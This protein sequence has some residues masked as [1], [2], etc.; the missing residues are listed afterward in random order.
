LTGPLAA[1]LALP[2]LRRHTPV[3]SEVLVTRSKRW[4]VVVAGIFTVSA[5]MLVLP[6]DASAQRR[7]VRRPAGR[8]V[9]VAPRV[10]R[11]IYRPVY[12]R[13]YYYPGWYSGWNNWYGIG[14]Y[15]FYGQPYYP[16]Y[17]RYDYTGSAR[18]Q[19]Q[20]REAQVFIDG[21]F[22]GE[23][24]DFDG[25]AQR[26]NVEPG[27]HDLEIALD[28]Y[29]SYREKVLFRPGATVNIKQVLEPLA[30]GA[31]PDPRPVPSRP[32]PA[33]R[34]GQPGDEQRPTERSGEPGRAAPPAPS[35]ESREYGAIAVRVQPADAEI[36]V[37][38]ER[39][40]SPEAGDVTI[41]LPDGPHTVEV[42]KSGYR[43]Y[44]ATVQVRRGE[45]ASINVS[46][47]R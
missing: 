20:P 22:V 37:D 8:P 19:V 3:W 21:Y 38:G 44:S 2:L 29:R 5:S 40:D 7:G 4:L 31:Q 47:S 35:G 14:P 39:W 18:L 33:A 9:V 36:L 45:T 11:P 43:T 1:L 13:P 32:A 46:L 26:L 12:Y 28:G 41:Q 17:H 23:V 30:P 15:S 6:A 24:D 42:R 10:H 16:Y 34:R 25:W 27:E